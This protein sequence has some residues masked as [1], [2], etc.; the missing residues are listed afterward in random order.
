M[1][2]DQ[3]TSWAIRNLQSHWKTGFTVENTR[4]ATVEELDQLI[5]KVGF[6]QKK[7]VYVD[8]SLS[9]HV[10]LLQ[11]LLFVDSMLTLRTCNSSFLKQIA[12]ICHDKYAGDIPSTVEEMVQLPG[13][14]PKMAY[15]TMNVAWQK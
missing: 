3:T 12:D 8:A 13:I 10:P 7:A 1:T 6:H 4:A 11:Q 15:L 9:F 2:K 14:G 5:C